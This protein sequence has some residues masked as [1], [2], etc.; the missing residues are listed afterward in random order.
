G[1]TSY[2]SEVG[3]M[4]VHTEQTCENIKAITDADSEPAYKIFTIAYDVANG[5]SVKDLLYNCASTNAAG[6]KYYYDVSGD[7]IASAMQAIGNEISD[8]RISQ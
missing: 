3:A 5:S 4:N 7:A 8:L 6:K 1:I 2:Q